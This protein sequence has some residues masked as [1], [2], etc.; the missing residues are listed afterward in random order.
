M[1][2]GIPEI[3]LQLSMQTTHAALPAVVRRQGQLQVVVEAPELVGEVGRVGLGRRGRIETHVETVD[4]PQ[5]V[6]ACRVAH[7]LQRARG[8]GARVGVHL[9]AGLRGQHGE[10][11]R[12][13][14]A[15][16]LVDRGHLWTQELV[17]LVGVDQ[18]RAVP[19]QPVVERGPYR[20]VER[21]H[22]AQLAVTEHD[23]LA[24]G[25]R[26]L[27]D[28]GQALLRLLGRAILGLRDE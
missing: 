13:G 15:G 24:R 26:G 14:Q 5:A 25:M 28:L 17:V 1:Q 2:T 23:R 10:Q 16:L 6:A 21:D 3:R 20:V 22:L 12:L 19:G 18:R 27:L 8:P 7:E 4:R 11:Q 9:A